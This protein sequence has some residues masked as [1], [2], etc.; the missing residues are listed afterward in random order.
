MLPK[1]LID[2]RAK[3]FPVHIIRVETFF[4]QAEFECS[5]VIIEFT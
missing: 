1:S 4:D 3:W 2:R 5:P